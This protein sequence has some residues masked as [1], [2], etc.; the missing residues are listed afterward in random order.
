MFKNCRK[1]S[2]LGKKTKNSISQSILKKTLAFKMSN[3]AKFFQ[4]FGKI[5]IIKKKMYLFG[6]YNQIVLKFVE[7]S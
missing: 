5:L 1:L 6:K 4:H 3:M 2:K 7:I